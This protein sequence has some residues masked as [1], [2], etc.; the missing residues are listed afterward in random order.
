MGVALG[1]GPNSGLMIALIY[2]REAVG[3][4]VLLHH[5]IW[6]RVNKTLAR[7]DTEGKIFN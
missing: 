7:T 6:L 1:F 2:P 5:P 3:P 4:K